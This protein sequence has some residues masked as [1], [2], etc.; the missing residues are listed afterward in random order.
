MDTARDVILKPVL[1]EKS[2]DLIPD[3]RYTF[4]VSPKATKSQIKAAVEEIFGVSVAS[5]NTTRKLGKIKRQGRTEGRRP[6]VKKAYITLKQGSK[7]IEFFES[8]AQ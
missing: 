3:M 6:E 8:M 4:E 7:K 1:S 2:Y 5:V